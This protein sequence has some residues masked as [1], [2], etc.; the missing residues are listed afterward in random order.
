M[1]T[2]QRK[3]RRNWKGWH[4]AALLLMLVALA[5]LAAG[6]GG[7]GSGKGSTTQV[8]DKLP[9]DFP[10]EP[11][12][13]KGMPKQYRE[14]YIWAAYHHEELQYIPCY[15][16]CGEMHGGNSACYYQRDAQGKVIAFDRHASA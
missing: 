13:F 7:G 12:W 15:C 1:A 14:A 11:A 5:G 8:A 9:E 16:G 10:A 3:L 2:E 6:C 4:L